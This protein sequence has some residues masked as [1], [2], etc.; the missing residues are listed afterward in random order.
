MNDKKATIDNAKMEVAFAK[1]KANPE[2]LTPVKKALDDMF[3]R[4]N[5][6]LNPQEQLTLIRRVFASGGQPLRDDP[7]PLDHGPE[8]GCHPALI[9]NQCPS[10]QPPPQPQRTPIPHATFNPLC[11]QEPTPIPHATFNP[12]CG[13]EPTPIPHATF[14]PLCG[15]K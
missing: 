15:Q 14:N 5:L 1:L 12:L 9:S 4:I 10:P 6:E 3:A 13:Q 2:A 8:E 7:V 11:G